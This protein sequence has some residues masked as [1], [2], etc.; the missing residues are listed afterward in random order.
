M[1]DS[2]Q[3]FTH[4]HIDENLREVV[5]DHMVFDYTLEKAL[6]R[7]GEIVVKANAD[8]YTPIQ[9]IAGSAS[10]YFGTAIKTQS[11]T[12]AWVV[13]TPSGSVVVTQNDDQS[14]NGLAQIY[15]MNIVSGLIVQEFI[16][17]KDSQ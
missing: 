15:A 14:E 9:K 7:V 12:N 13:S 17:H 6:E 1:N 16:K 8:G 3:P 10:D 11:A 2:L 5:M 4:I